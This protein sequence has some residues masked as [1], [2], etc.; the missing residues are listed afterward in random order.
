M[1]IIEPSAELYGEKWVKVPFAP[2]YEVDRRGRVRNATTGNFIKPWMRPQSN[3]V[4]HFHVDGKIKKCTKNSLVWLTHGKILT[5]NTHSRLPVPVIIS[6]G[7]ERYYFDTCRQ[8]AF[9]LAKRDG[10]HTAKYT[11]TRFA[12]RLKEIFGWKINYQR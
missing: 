5:S 12:C 4:Y 11:V 10:N 9:Y 8:A 2:N 6:H 1:K 7:N 3:G